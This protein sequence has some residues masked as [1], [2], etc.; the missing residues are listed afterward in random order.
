M[1]KALGFILKEIIPRINKLVPNK[2][3]FHIFGAKF[4]KEY[5]IYLRNDVIYNGYVEDLGA[6]LDDMDVALIPSFFGAGMQL[7]IFEPPSRGIPTITS[8]RGLAGYPLE[9][10][11]HVLLA[12]STDK[13]VEHLI[14]LQDINLRRS[15]SKES[16]KICN[17]LFSQ[18]S[19]DL[20]ILDEIKKL[21][22]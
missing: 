3:C 12:S 20:I 7:K 8:P 13:F 22:K 14:N 11:K 1:K 6:A 10:G 5:N 15:L 21:T 9:D 17:R 2:F 4:P 18:E 16:L 19:F